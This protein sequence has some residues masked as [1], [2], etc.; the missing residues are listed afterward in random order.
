[1]K[2]NFFKATFFIL[3]L[4]S[5]SLCFAQG[6][7][8]EGNETSIFEESDLYIDVYSAKYRS[9]YQDQSVSAGGY[10]GIGIISNAPNTS[11]NNKGALGA[12]TI[13]TG[14]DVPVDSEIIYLIL[15]G[16][17]FGVYKTHKKIAF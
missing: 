12:P 2:L 6:D 5:N 1:M 13:P 14:P 7:P 3:F 9:I 4:F 15:A 11:P 17:I 16:L 10:L 8:W